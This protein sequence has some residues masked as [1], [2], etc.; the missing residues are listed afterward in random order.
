MSVR[1]APP[2]AVLQ[3][4]LHEPYAEL[5]T[6]EDFEPPDGLHLGERVYA[7]VALPNCPGEHA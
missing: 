5:A 6:E 3:A 1:A 4:K 7:R 2:K